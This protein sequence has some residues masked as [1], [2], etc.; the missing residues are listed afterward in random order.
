MKKLFVLAV[1]TAFLIFGCVEQ[2]VPKECTWIADLTARD[3][4]ILKAAV[5]NQDPFTCYN[6]KNETVKKQC[7]SDAT[8]LEKK[9]AYETPSAEAVVT[10]SCL[11]IGGSCASE[12]ECCSGYCD[13]TGKCAAP[14]S[15]SGEACG[16]NADCCAGLCSKKICVSCLELNEQCANSTDCCSGYCVRGNCSAE[17]ELGKGLNM[18]DEA[19]D[20]LIP[21][22]KEN[23]TMR[24]TCIDA[25]AFSKKEI[26]LCTLIESTAVKNGCVNKI[27]TT[28]KNPEIC[29]V[30]TGDE[31]T[32]CLLY[33]AG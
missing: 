17:E 28:V 15:K 33:S 26:L 3:A 29:T 4:C 5:Q 12:T 8:T 18:S 16:Q 7:F 30:L 21:C 19:R 13:T 1:I 20:A 24:E 27:A 11:E 6:I 9:G 14:C 23:G 22:G 25:V 31:K 32:L 2:P 10:P